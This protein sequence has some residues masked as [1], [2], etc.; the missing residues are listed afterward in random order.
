M[1]MKVHT[2][3]FCEER[4]HEPYRIRTFFHNFYEHGA[5][6]MISDELG[7]AR[8]QIENVYRRFNPPEYGNIK[9]VRTDDT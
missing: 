1:V 9:V 6:R 8:E 4:L 5:K 2:V 7:H 3:T